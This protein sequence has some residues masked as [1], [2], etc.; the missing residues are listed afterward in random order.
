M[1]AAICL[2]PGL[3]FSQEMPASAV[4][5]YLDQ[6]DALDVLGFRSAGSASSPVTNDKIIFIPGPYLGVNPTSGTILGVGTNALFYLGDPASTLLSTIDNLVA[7][8][9]QHQFI[10]F[11]KST[12][13][14]E[15][16]GW[17]FQGDW[18]YYRFSQPLGELGTNT[19]ASMDEGRTQSGGPVRVLSGDQ[20]ITFD[21][22]RVH[23]TAFKRLA[24]NFYA[25]LGYSL[26]DHLHIADS[27]FDPAGGEQ[28]ITQNAA[29]SFYHGFD[30]AHYVTSGISADFLFESRDHVLNAYQGQYLLLAYT[31]NSAN[32]G[33][34]RDS[35]VFYGEYRKYVPLSPTLPRHILGFWAFANLVA[36][37]EVPYLR[38]S[39]RRL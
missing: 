13:L 12:V 19:Q 11:S 10:F 34:S 2:L 20:L 18:R 7:Y 15:N 8:S 17:E 37:G 28:T 29:Y 38:S 32:L 22:L 39:G 36:R 3:S 6:T 30:P 9:T 14:T 23:E 16:N 33:S 27:A 25:G 35:Q 26:D 4:A 31:F 24:E 1:L 21:Y 5:D